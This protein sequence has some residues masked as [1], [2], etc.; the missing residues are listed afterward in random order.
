[1]YKYPLATE[2]VTSDFTARDS[3]GGGATEDKPWI[4]GAND[5]LVIV[6]YTIVEFREEKEWKEFFSEILLKG[7]GYKR[8]MGRG[9]L[10]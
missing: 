10:I 7:F 4:A 1:M 8:K 3:G 5:E 2:S 9:V 6:E